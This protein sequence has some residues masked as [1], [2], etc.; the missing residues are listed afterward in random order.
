MLH[1]SARPG[2][3]LRRLAADFIGAQIGRFAAEAVVVTG[4]DFTRVDRRASRLW[5][6]VDGGDI[7]NFFRILRSFLEGLA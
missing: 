2:T 7:E 5:P 1:L 3:V 4:Q 6:C